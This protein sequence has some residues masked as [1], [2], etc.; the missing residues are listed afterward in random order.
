MFQSSLWLDN[1]CLPGQGLMMAPLR[2]PGND[3]PGQSDP[4]GPVNASKRFDG[5]VSL[6]KHLMTRL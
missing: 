5:W 2:R 3:W 1:T 6:L 4:D